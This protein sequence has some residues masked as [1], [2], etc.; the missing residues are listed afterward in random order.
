MAEAI[1]KDLKVIGI[2][3]KIET[4]TYTGNRPAV[5]AR[6]NG[7]WWL[8]ADSGGAPS[9]AFPTTETWAHRRNPEAAF[10]NGWELPQ[11]VVLSKAM[12]ECDSQECIDEGRMAMFD[13]W[14]KGPG[15][16]LHRELVWSDGTLRQGGRVATAAGDWNTPRQPV[17]PGVRPETL[18]RV[19]KSFLD[20]A[21]LKKTGASTRG[22]RFSIPGELS[23]GIGWR[24]APC[25]SADC[26]G[27]NAADSSESTP[28]ERFR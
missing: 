7:D 25:T 3:V 20:L 14:A 5:V 15:L 1:A 26:R 27:S 13:W 18:G 11:A 2:D 23:S 6:E 16:C 22:P 8:Q 12:E 4:L 19:S 10:N 24:P 21:I 17:Q 28:W 9:A